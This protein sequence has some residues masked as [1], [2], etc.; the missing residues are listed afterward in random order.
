MG[1]MTNEHHDGKCGHS[2]SYGYRDHEQ[3]R[4]KNA[5]FVAQRIQAKQRIHKQPFIYSQRLRRL[6]KMFV[7]FWGGFTA[8]KQNKHLCEPRSYE[9][10]IAGVEQKCSIAS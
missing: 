6:A 10:T 9:L 2:H 4:A 3:D 7:L 5:Y 8:P 1:H